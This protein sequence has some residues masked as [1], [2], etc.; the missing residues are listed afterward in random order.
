M[1]DKSI[2]INSLLFYRIFNGIFTGGNKRFLDFFIPVI[3]QDDKI[4]DIGCGL[5]EGINYLAEII[6]PLGI[7]PYT[8]I[9][10]SKKLI[11]IAK[12]KYPYLYFEEGDICD[13]D[14]Y[15][16]VFN[17]V[18]CSFLFHHLPSAAKKKGLQEIKRILK[19][20]GY[21]MYI[22]YGKPNNLFTKV[23]MNLMKY[24]LPWWYEEIPSQMNNEVLTMMVD[25]GFVIDRKTVKTVMNGSVYCV[26]ARKPELMYE[27]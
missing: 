19:P 15:K 26:L 5:G 3:K 22:D 12:K 6:V 27:K 13:I 8:G 4:L 18:L 24:V 20:G 21:L 14:I 10:K 9:D 16:N 25:E 2:V 1:K 7:Q 23:V 17:K 11:N